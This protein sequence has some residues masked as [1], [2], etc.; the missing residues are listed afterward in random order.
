MNNLPKILSGVKIIQLTD[1]Q[2]AALKQAYADV[3]RTVPVLTS[4]IEIAAVRRRLVGF[5]H[6]LKIESTRSSARFCSAKT[7]SFISA[8]K[9]IIKQLDRVT[10]G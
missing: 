5:I 8:A 3:D 7:V 4:T 2:A 9:S 1:T 10:H 6:T